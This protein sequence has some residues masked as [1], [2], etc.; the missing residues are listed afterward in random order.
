M[1]RLRMDAPPVT[2]ILANN[3]VVSVQTPI[4]NH[5]SDYCASAVIPVAGGHIVY[6]AVDGRAKRKPIKLGAAVA[7]GF[8]VSPASQRATLLSPVAMNSYPMAR[9]SNMAV[10]EIKQSARLVADGTAY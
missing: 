5:S 9:R 2:T 10:Q 1:V 6:L 4:A 8:V 7:S 3:A